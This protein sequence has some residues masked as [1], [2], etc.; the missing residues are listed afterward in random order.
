M[1]WEDFPLSVTDAPLRK[2]RRTADNWMDYPKASS[3]E[4]NRKMED[5]KRKDHQAFL[6]QRD[7]SDKQEEALMPAEVKETDDLLA[8][9]LRPFA[10]ASSSGDN[11]TALATKPGKRPP[12]ECPY[13]PE[14]HYPPSNAS[15]VPSLRTPQ[16]AAPGHFP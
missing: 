15:K 1:D 11:P 7:S 16:K 13:C 2:D 4:T 6:A 10:A 14:M 5:R 3:E 12:P 9:A 8:S